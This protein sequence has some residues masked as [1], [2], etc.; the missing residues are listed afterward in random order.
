MTCDGT[1]SDQLVAG[2]VWLWAWSTSADVSGWSD[3]VIEFRDSS[4]IL[5]ASNVADGEGVA[6]VHTTEIGVFPAT[7]FGAG[8]FTWWVDSASRESWPPVVSMEADVLDS[9]VASTVWPAAPYRVMSDVA[10]RVA[11]S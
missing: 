4:G 5:L 2:D 8:L 7:D 10:R 3:P 9:G 1:N 11:G 6:V